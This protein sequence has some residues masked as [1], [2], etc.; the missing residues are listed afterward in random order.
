MLRAL[1]ELRELE[2]R[3]AWTW[4]LAQSAEACL[5]EGSVAEAIDQRG[6]PLR[7]FRILAHSPFIA[8]ARGFFLLYWFRVLRPAS[9]AFMPSERLS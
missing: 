9:I 2:A 1:D 8:A 4:R 7:L 5:A 3:Q 6:L